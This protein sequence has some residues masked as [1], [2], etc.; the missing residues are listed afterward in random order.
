VLLYA[1][2][3]TDGPG[4]APKVIAAINEIDQPG[5]TPDVQARFRLIRAHALATQGDGRQAASLALEALI[6]LDWP[7]AYHNSVR[8]GALAWQRRWDEAADSY[9]KAMEAFE[10]SGQPIE[11]TG[12]QIALADTLLEIG[13]TDRALAEAEG[14]LLAAGCSI[15]QAHVAFAESLIGRALL[16]TGDWEA[17]TAWLGV[18]LNSLEGLGWMRSEAVLALTRLKAVHNLGTEAINRLGISLEKARFDAEW[19]T[20]RLRSEDLAAELASLSHTV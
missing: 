16:A 19:H 9:E 3:D 7:P 6:T 17:G 10:I 5:L 4:Y 14:A 12:A 20:D 13:D 1:W 8:A 2:L 15:N 11:R 18:A